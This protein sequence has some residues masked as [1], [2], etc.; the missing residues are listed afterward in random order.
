MT[1]EARISPAAQSLKQEQADQRTTA[2][3]GE[4]DTGLEDSFPAS[5]PVSMTTSSISGGRTDV[6]EAEKVK[7]QAE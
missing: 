7:T 4:L 2:A 6:E 3:K 5:D 1:D